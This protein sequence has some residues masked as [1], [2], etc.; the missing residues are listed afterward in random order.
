MVLFLGQGTKTEL[1]Y[2][3]ICS[4]EWQ[5][6][7]DARKKIKEGLYLKEERRDKNKFDLGN[8]GHRSNASSI[9]YF[10]C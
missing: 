7:M 8:I 6:V 5:H 4:F 10:L 9:F 3:L 2:S 1:P